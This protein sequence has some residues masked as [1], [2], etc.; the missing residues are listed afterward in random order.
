VKYPWF[1]YLAALLTCLFLLAGC[2]TI[3]GFLNYGIPTSTVTPNPS[4]L[5]ST[6]TISP[7]TTLAPNEFRVI[8]AQACP[9]TSFNAL[10]ADTLQTGS[11]ALKPGSYGIAYVA[12]RSDQQWYNGDLVI[13]SG[14]NF[15]TQTSLSNNIQVVGDL[16]WSPDGALIAFVAFRQEDNVYTVMVTRE[17][18][19]PIDLFPDLAARSDKFSSPKTLLQWK[20]NDTISVALSC[21]VDCAQ[22]VDINVTDSTSSSTSSGQPTDLPVRKGT[23]IPAAVAN[24]ERSYDV[25][26]FPTMSN[27]TWSPDG[28][29][30]AYLNDTSDPWLLSINDRTIY[31]LN[32]N[33]ALV[34]EMKWSLDGKMIALHLDGSIEIFKIGCT[35]S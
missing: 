10:R 7:N 20:N 24:D 19:S 9:I 21:G 12:P 2:S 13:A 6:S 15:A 27:P 17:K 1:A 4:N 11:L 30:V 16:L 3:N 34:V 35:A 28:N 18:G 5:Q 31:P 29:L 14:P 26:L 32:V 23:L 22:A 8:S 33:G 25:K